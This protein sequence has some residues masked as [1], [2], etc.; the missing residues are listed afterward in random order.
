VALQVTT[1]PTEKLKRNLGLFDVY[2]VSTGAMFSSGFFLLPGVAMA[3][4]G[5]SV[6]LAYLL[7]SFII[8]PA[9]FSMAELTTAM[10]RAGGDY[11]CIDRSLGPLAGT[12]GGLGTW[13]ALVLKSA[14]ALVG[15]GAYLTL[16]LDLPIRPIAA[17]LTIVFAVLN[18]VG[19]K[20]STNLQ[21]ILVAALVSIMVF[22]CIQ[23]L[24]SVASIGFTGVAADRF[25][26]FLSSGVQGLFGTVGLVFVSYA[27]LTKVASIAEEVRTPDRNIPLGMILALLTTIT[28]YVVGV[29][30]MVAILPSGD[31]V[32]SLTPVADAGAAFL[33]WLPGPVLL[34]LIVIAAIAAFASTAN[35]GILSASRYPLAMSR[36]HL[37]PKPFSSI[38]RYKTPT[39]SIIVT[40]SLM[41][42]AVL[43]LDVANIAKLASAFQLMIF[44]LINLSV[45]VMRESR[46]SSYVPGFES[47]LYPWLQIFGIVASVLLIVEIGRASTMFTLLLVAIAIIW[48]YAYARANVEREGAIYHIYARLGKRRFE[49]LDHE[50][51]DILKE[52]E[53]EESDPYERIV[54]QARVFDFEAVESYEVIVNRVADAL[55]KDVAYSASDL[56]TMFLT[57]QH[58][59]ATAVSHGAA[60]PELRLTNITQTQIV[61]V[62]I[63]QGL[64]LELDD[65]AG[66][67]I[68]ANQPVHAVIFLLSPQEKTGQHLRILAELVSRVDE[69]GFLHEWHAAQDDNSLREVFLRHERFVQIYLNR[70]SAV[71]D[72]VGKHAA[73]L[74]LPK[75]TL[76]A[77]IQRDGETLVPQAD[78]TLQAGD[79]LTIIG[80]P[81][82][83]N[84]LYEAYH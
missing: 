44:A 58:I 84:E 21:R 52:R 34:I 9:M 59:G 28:I 47:P 5:P 4:T 50:L 26:P 64:K 19:A 41:L 80:D 10:P 72:F 70:P 32:N 63:Q 29:Y 40:S 81:R 3:E 57:G 78:T 77:L 45:I 37:I 43:F 68:A 30:I 33:N 39:F 69:E 27:G 12:I 7:S 66:K 17:V 25:T 65:V 62:R 55:A 73:D 6:V 15:I 13:L 42:F 11:Y 35:A 46:I 83:V 75:G 61:L 54:S 76:L 56:E 67:R 24:A 36:D 8:A 22:Y 2:A 1:Q 20:E 79:C 38:G 48:Y 16:F 51:R 74:S 49:G 71:N 82:H 53:L 31:L 23:G 14:F 60:L 18:I